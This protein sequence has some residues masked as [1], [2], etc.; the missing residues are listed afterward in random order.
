MVDNGER[1]GGRKGGKEGGREGRWREGGRRE[2]GRGGR[3]GGGGERKGGREVLYVYCNT[4]RE[5][6]HFHNFSLSIPPQ[7]TD[8]SEAASAAV[9][10]MEIKHGEPL[11]VQFAA[12]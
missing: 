2:G 3:E 7:I 5:R 11:V 12:P 10:S 9:E 6:E 8:R 4:R 1:K